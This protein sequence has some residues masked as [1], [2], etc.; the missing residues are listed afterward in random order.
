M[1]HEIMWVELKK[2]VERWLSMKN[3]DG[4]DDD[5]WQD[6]EETILGRVQ[7]TMNDLEKKWR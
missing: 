1:N 7:D 2:K 5:V 4:F 6:A 3:S